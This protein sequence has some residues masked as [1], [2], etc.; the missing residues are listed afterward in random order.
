MS[1]HLFGGRLNVAAFQELAR[2]ELLSLMEPGPKVRT[3]THNRIY[4][5]SHL[6]NFVIL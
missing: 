3:Y 1:S 5:F 4:L 6:L 2:K